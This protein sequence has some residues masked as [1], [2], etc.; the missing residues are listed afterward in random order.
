MAFQ[1]TASQ[2]SDSYVFPFRSVWT[3]S[4]ALWL[5][6]TRSNVVKMKLCDIWGSIRSSFVV[7]LFL[8]W[9]TRFGEGSHHVH[10]STTLMLPC[11]E[12]AQVSQMG[13]E[14]PSQPSAVPATLSKL[15]PVSEEATEDV[16][17]N[18]AFRRHQSSQ[19]LTANTR[20]PEQ[21]PHS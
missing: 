13:R 9:N 1:R 3:G 16:M 8:S 20:D 11:W 5:D 19:H 15:H 14:M 7:S 17:P 6:W 2:Y 10:Y 21:E 12:E 18:W 4:L